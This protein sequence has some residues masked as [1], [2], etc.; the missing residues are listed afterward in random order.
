MTRALTGDYKCM[1]SNVHGDSSTTDYLPVNC[2]FFCCPHLL[3]FT[4]LY[5]HTWG[6]HFLAHYWQTCGPLNTKILQT[7]YL[8]YADKPE[9]AYL[10]TEL[11]DLGAL[12][13]S[14]T[15]LQCMSDGY[16]SPQYIIKRYEGITLK[17]TIEKTDHVLF[18]SV[19]FTDEQFSY[20]CTPF[21][22]LGKG[23]ESPK[24]KIKV[25][26]KTFKHL[27]KLCSFLKI[28]CTTLVYSACNSSFLQ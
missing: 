11:P 6:I 7:I 14:R 13:N 28:T 26:G 8:F 25:I 15:K 2:E 24:E 17:E 3:L 1:A 20:T 27:L 12:L 18:P 10:K 23:P 16:P 21:N 4:P 9:K 22:F 5:F 19:K